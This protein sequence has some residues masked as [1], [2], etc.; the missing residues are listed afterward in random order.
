MG[1][2]PF[3]AYWADLRPLDHPI[4]QQFGGNPLDLAA[5]QL[6]LDQVSTGGRD[7]KMI[8]QVQFGGGGGHLAGGQIRLPLGR[9]DVNFPKHRGSSWPG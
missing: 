1:T 9:V 7:L 6:A 5:V 2:V 3:S 4:G 8:G